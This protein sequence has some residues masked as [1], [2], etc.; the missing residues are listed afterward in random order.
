VAD[1]EL[2]LR[3]QVCERRAQLVA[4]VRYEA[5]LPLE[6]RLEARKHLVQRLAEPRDLVT[7][8][9]SRKPASGLRGRDGLGLGA[10]RVHGAK[11]RRRERIA[12]RRCE[13]ERDRPD[14]G[15][16]DQERASGL[17]TVFERGSD[18]H[19]GRARVAGDR[20]REDARTAGDTR[21]VSELG[22]NAAA[23][24]RLRE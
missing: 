2:E 11:R 20:A 21:D 18:D 13:D 5:P 3:L 23:C 7:A 16:Q 19:Y 15:E 24:P 17:V 8:G 14:D 1:G 4:R 6:C 10:H 22:A 12:E 9:R